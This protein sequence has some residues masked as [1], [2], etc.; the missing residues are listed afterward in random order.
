MPI[1]HHKTRNT[2]LLF[3]ILIAKFIIEM[4]DVDSSKPSM[5]IIKKYFSSST[6]LSKDLKICELLSDNTTYISKE[7][8][9]KYIVE[10]IERDDVNVNALREE[11]Y[12]LGGA[13]KDTYDMKEF[14]STDIKNYTTMASV[15][16]LLSFYRE[17]E[18][19]NT[20][21]LKDRLVCENRIKEILTLPS[22]PKSKSVDR[23]TKLSKFEQTLLPITFRKKYEGVLTDAQMTVVWK[24]M[25]YDVNFLQEE[26]EKLN[27]ELNEVISTVGDELKDKVN[28]GMEKLQTTTFDPDHPKEFESNVK[29]LLHTHSLITEIKKL[30]GISKTS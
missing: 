17:G 11:H 26:T 25:K 18:V 28:G 15:Y 12:K 7:D 30:N 16:K 2:L 29:I 13:I 22:K 1:K 10:I 19:N 20:G 23:L 9:D 8:V 24:G 5:P 27:K 14:F 6:E 3:E 21:N 4:K